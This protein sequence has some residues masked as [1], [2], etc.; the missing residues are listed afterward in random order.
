MKC[1]SIEYQI[2]RPE[3]DSRT[4]ASTFEVLP[5][6]E[7]LPAQVFGV[8]QD[9]TDAKRA[10]KREFER[11]KLE[12]VGTLAGGIAH[13]FNN[14]LG[15]VLSQAELALADIGRGSYPEE[16]LKSIQD[17]AI[18]GSEIVREL[19]IYAGQDNAVVGPVNVS[20]V[21]E[22]MLGLLKISVSKHATLEADLDAG[23]PA[24]WGNA[25]Q[26]GQIAM[27]LVTNASQAIGAQD[28]RDPRE[29]QARTCWRGRVNGNS[30]RFRRRGRLR[31]TGGRRHWHRYVTGNAG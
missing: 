10:Q 31:S 30:G 25:A 1:H 21:V 22:E 23:L 29:H 17:V 9:I 14:L 6:Q 13:D 12:T 18:R 2:R 26:V 7:G 15:G 20:R 27:N 5:D 3:G 19:M 4:V 28:G 24:V 16:Q 11:Q 8:C